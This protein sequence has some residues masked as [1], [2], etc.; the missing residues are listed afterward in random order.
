MSKDLHEYAFD[1]SLVAAIRVQAPSI[2]EA[3][4]ILHERL[5]AADV[6]AGCWENGDPILFEASIDYAN[7]PEIY[8]IDGEPA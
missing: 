1:V 7:P 5:D 6:N 4:K 3:L 2:G 8:E